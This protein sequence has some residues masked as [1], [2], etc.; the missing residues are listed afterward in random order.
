M[1]PFIVFFVASMIAMTVGCDGDGDGDISETPS[2]T[3]GDPSGTGADEE[4]DLTGGARRA[5][6]L[7]ESG[8]GV[9]PWTPGNIG[10]VQL[11][12]RSGVLSCVYTWNAPPTTL[13]CW[14]AQISGGSDT[15]S[16]RPSIVLF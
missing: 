10:S 8:G 1:K 12:D 9:P 14:L 13:T 15:F 2:P 4:G 11:G 16:I 5:E 3:P 7:L 6:V